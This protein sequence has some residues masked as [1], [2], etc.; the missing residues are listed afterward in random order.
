MYSPTN[1][2]MI[3]IGVILQ[4][5]VYNKLTAWDLQSIDYDVI[6]GPEEF[7]VYVRLVD[8]EQNVLYYGINPDRENN[9]GY[10]PA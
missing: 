7:T 5:Q 9:Y 8:K 6:P 3:R 2:Q 1:A 4:T 10:L